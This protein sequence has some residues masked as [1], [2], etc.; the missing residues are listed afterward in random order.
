MPVNLRDSINEV[1]AKLDEV[2]RAIVPL[3]LSRVM[4][5]LSGSQLPWILKSDGQFRQQFCVHMLDMRLS[6]STYKGLRL[7]TLRQGHGQGPP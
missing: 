7:S 3:E 1:C 5:A 2:N 4:Q 6:N